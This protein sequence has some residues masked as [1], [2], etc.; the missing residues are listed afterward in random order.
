VEAAVQEAK[1]KATEELT[2]ALRA[3]AEVRAADL[4]VL[5]AC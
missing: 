4:A 5:I 2:A 1:S 3:A